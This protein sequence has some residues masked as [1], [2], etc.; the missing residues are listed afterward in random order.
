MLTDSETN[1]LVPPPL[2]SAPGLNFDPDAKVVTIAGT[3]FS[4]HD[5]LR[6]FT[7]QENGPYFLK[8]SDVHLKVGQPVRCRTDGDLVPMEGCP[9]LSTDQIYR[10]ICPLLSPPQIAAFL[11]D[12][13]VDID[14]SLKW[15]DDSVVV[16][17]N[18]FHD[19]DGPALVIRLLKNCPPPV[20]KL[21]FKD[22]KVW[23]SI[24]TL[25]Q[26]LVLVSGVTGSG[27]STTVAS[28]LQHINRTDRIRM[29]TIE[30]PIEYTFRSELA[31]VSQR[32]IGRQLPS[33]AAGL[34]SALR[35]DPD[36]IFVGEIRDE[37]TAALTV[38]AAQTG[39]VV[40]ATTHAKDAAGALT[41]IVDLF[42]MERSKEIASN[43]SHSLAWVLAQKLVPKIGGGR[44]LAM[45]VLKA[46]ST[47][48][49]NI[50]NQNWH[51][52]YSLMQS[53]GAE[54]MTTMERCLMD[55]VKRGLITKEEAMASANAPE[56]LMFC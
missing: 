17:L 41:R 53:G 50:R 38:A 15:G 2:E 39:H 27:K 3:E 23:Q 10:L 48:C 51:Q 19:S 30:D 1:S 16:R 31:L 34:K 26:G 7:R 25:R 11:A 44:V 12:D 54:G 47:V 49:T 18:A 55:L 22:D 46:T 35:E 5:L 29:I 40:V 42:P 37:A 32:E 56:H 13:P 14:T 52:I 43:L 8:C 21:G 33:V 4:I 28:I 9:A 36:L 24:A 20:E 6:H 45:E